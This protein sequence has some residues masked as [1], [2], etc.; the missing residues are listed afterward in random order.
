MKLK[1]KKKCFEHAAALN[2]DAEVMGCYIEKRGLHGQSRANQ[3]PLQSLIKLHGTQ[4]AGRAYPH[5]SLGKCQLALRT[6]KQSLLPLLHSLGAPAV[7]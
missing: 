2:E 4:H 3:W 7:L 1:K 5:C 6:S